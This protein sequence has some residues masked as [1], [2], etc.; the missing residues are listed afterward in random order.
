MFDTGKIIDCINVFKRVMPKCVAV[1]K[2]DKIRVLFTTDLIQTL[3][4]F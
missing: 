2:F 3:V 1:N 4:N